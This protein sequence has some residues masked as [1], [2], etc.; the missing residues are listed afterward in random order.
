MNE[1]Q[2]RA[3]HAQLCSD[4]AHHNHRYHVLDDPQISDAAYDSLMRELLALEAAWPM[5][6]TDVS[7]S[8]R[9]GATA[10]DGF[11]EIEH[12]L[13]MLSLENAFDESDVAAFDRR[14]RE[15][16]SEEREI[17]YAVEPKLDGLAVALLYKDG[18]LVY[19]AT[20][21]DGATG[22]DIT[23]NIRTI[24]AVP[25][26]LLGEP[27]GELEVRGEVFMPIAGFLQMNADAAARGEK[28][29]VNPRN[30][31]A[32]S[33][34]QLDPRVTAGRPLDIFFYALGHVSGVV[35][36]DRQS[37][38][39]AWFRELGLRTCPQAKA[40]RGLR[41][42]L[43]YFAEIGRQRDTLPYQID[44]VVYKVDQRSLQERLGF[45]S[46]APRWAI[47]HKYPAEEVET[48]L[49]DVEF[50][51]GRTGALTPVARLVPVFVGGVTVSNAT[52]HNMDKVARKDVRIG[53]TVIVR[54]AGDVIPEVARVLIERRPGGTRPIVLPAQCPV[55]GSSVVRDPDQAVARCTGGFQ[56]AA[57]RKEGLRHFASRRAMNID[58]LGDKLVGQLVEAGLLT[59]PADIYRLSAPQLSGL[60]RMGDKS[61]AKLLAAINASRATTLP[62]LLYALGIRDVGEATALALARHFGDVDA[63]INADAAAIQEVQDVGPVI[64]AQVAA[65]WRE[66]ANRQLLAELRERGVS[67]PPLP[68]R[69][70]AAANAAATESSPL[71]GRTFVLT[72]T[73]GTMSRDEAEDKLRDLGAKVSGSVSRKTTAVIAGAEAGSKLSKAVELGVPVLDESQ[74]QAIISSRRYPL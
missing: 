71:A 34:R 32:G 57:Q 4:I 44:G 58:G 72:G 36:P 40:V 30:A 26:R 52:L 28:Q 69:V 63:L 67:W 61:A 21:G 12:R 1:A 25:L 41:G 7:P 48:E 68:P 74:L 24:P 46:R 18:S 33:L 37:L 27:R 54:R 19:G 65:Y 13:P 29:F 6:V 49:R 50:Q 22:E 8:Q 3:R 55:C 64:A 2:A 70:V 56:C 14:V 51:V 23:A 62:R 10:R 15:R 11:A 9:V 16:L 17:D 66:P 31:A 35:P 43:D 45:V 39:L 47:A 59:T 42:C 38:L 73:L 53:D 5:F 20:R 60:D